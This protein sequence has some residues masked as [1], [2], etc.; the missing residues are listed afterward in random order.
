MNDLTTSSIIRFL[1][2]HET[3][4]HR[5]ADRRAGKKGWPSPFGARTR[6]KLSM[7][8]KKFRARSNAGTPQSSGDRRGE[9]E[10]VCAS[11]AAIIEK[12][13]HEKYL[14]FAVP[15]A[16][17]TRRSFLRLCSM[18]DRDELILENTLIFRRMIRFL[19]RICTIIQVYVAL[20]TGGIQQK[21]TS[22][23]CCSA[24]GVAA[25]D[26]GGSNVFEDALL[27]NAMRDAEQITKRFAG[28]R[29]EVR[30][31][32]DSVSDDSVG[33]TVLRRPDRHVRK[34]ASIKSLFTDSASIP[35]EKKF[36]VSVRQK[37]IRETSFFRKR[38]KNWKNGKK[39]LHIEVRIILKG[40]EE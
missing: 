34:E 13:E 27:V 29:S 10:T 31:Y 2:S 25:N 20:G 39:V 18:R 21:E 15:L 37:I 40:F 32:S 14:P 35:R 16:Q 23:N 11:L 7:I 3:Y 38:K 6:K 19:I 17:N 4:I 36:P 1:K 28:K 9:E 5:I 24:F 26:L 8:G 30:I 33:R 22:L 12:K